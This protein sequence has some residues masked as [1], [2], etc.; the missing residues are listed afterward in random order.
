M[1]PDSAERRA[2]YRAWARARGVTEAR[3][4]AHPERLWGEPGLGWD[5]GR[6]P[7]LDHARLW[8]RDGRVACL[9]AEPYGLGDASREELRRLAQG[10]ALEVVV[11]P[12]EESL[13]L[14]GRT[15]LIELWVAGAPLKKGA[16]RP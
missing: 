8:A 9:T 3:G 7:W 10:H 15:V 14:P 6:Y 16:D 1:D 5:Q 2:R 11:R 13:H 12:P 4:H